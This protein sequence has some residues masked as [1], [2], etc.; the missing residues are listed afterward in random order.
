MTEVRDARE[1]VDGVIYA[2]A[3]RNLSPDA[4]G[5]AIDRELAI[6]PLS[7]DSALLAFGSDSEGRP[8][9][10][11]YGVFFSSAEALFAARFLADESAPPS[12]QVIVRRAVDPRRGGRELAVTTCSPALT[13]TFYLRLVRRSAMEPVETL[14]EALNDGFVTER[15]FLDG[16]RRAWAAAEPVGDAAMRGYLSMHEVTHERLAP[17]SAGLIAQALSPRVPPSEVA[18][19]RDYLVG[20]GVV[21]FVS[22]EV[23]WDAHK[24]GLGRVLVDEFTCLVSDV[25]RAQELGEPDVGALDVPGR[26]I[27]ARTYVIV[28]ERGRDGVDLERLAYRLASCARSGEA[29]LSWKP[30]EL[31]EGMREYRERRF[32]REAPRRLR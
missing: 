4:L 2:G 16:T 14:R 31:L 24:D 7:F 30:S 28:D 27:D 11:D 18:R 5:E 12:G 1:P 29:V 21:W 17:T 9:Q 6:S 15:E 19:A 10:L 26:R 3:A 8:T 22:T 25:R 20:G 23:L 32:D 13:A